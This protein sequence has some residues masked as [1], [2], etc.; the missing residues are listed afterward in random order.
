M[1]N[2]L[3]IVWDVDPIIFQVKGLRVA[4]YGLLFA[5]GL[6]ISYY[7]MQWIFKKEKEPIEKLDRF[8]MFTIIGA[9]LGARF[10]HILFY[11]PIYYWNHPM[12]ILKVWHGGLASH[13]GA[14]GIFIAIA[15]YQRKSERSYLWLLDKIAIPTALTGAMIR[16]GNLMNSEIYGEPTDLPWGF[17]FKRMNETV[18]MHPTQIYESLGYLAIFI[19]L[20]FYYKKNY[21]TVNDGKIL[22][23]FFVL[24]FGLRFFVEFI[25]YQQSAMIAGT[26]SVLT[27][28]QYLSIPIV[29]VGFYLI[30][31]K[32]SK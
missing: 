19:F 17:I 4:Y 3:S 23:F 30:F 8:A 13:G 18:P 21:A 15:I 25:K 16:L 12:E 28:G 14:I 26:E 7:I 10:G 29:L 1:N 11:D 20:F 27:M 6:A 24:V 9:V 32:K 2:I 31:R 22:G 5:G